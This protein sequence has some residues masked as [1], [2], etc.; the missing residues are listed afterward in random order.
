MCLVVILPTLQFK[1]RIKVPYYATAK[2]GHI[3]QLFHTDNNNVPPSA[4]EISDD[5]F[6]LVRS[7]PHLYSIQGGRVVFDEVAKYQQDKEQALNYADKQGE[8]E[9][10][11][12]A[13]IQQ[14]LFVVMR[15]FLLMNKV[16]TLDEDRELAEAMDKLSTIVEIAAITEEIAAEIE[17]TSEPSAVK[18]GARFAEKKEARKAKK[19]K[20]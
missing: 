7:S 11:A 19:A 2:A 9:A 13:S 14:Q 18:I 8:A 5:D 4:L 15:S 3:D 20:K 6:L 12:E 16:R 1:R 17:E 10:K